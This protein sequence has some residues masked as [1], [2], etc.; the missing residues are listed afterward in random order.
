MK[1]FIKTLLLI[2]L[3]LI[4]FVLIFLLYEINFYNYS[5]FKG[6]FVK[7]MTTEKNDGLFFVYETVRYPSNV[8]IIELENNSNLTLGL[9]NEPWN[10]NFGVMP[11]GILSKRFINLANGKEEIYK[12]EIHVYG[13]ISPM[14]S[15]DKNNFILKKGDEMKVTALL[16]STLSKETGKYIG[17]VD[18]ISKRSK[19][20]FF[21]V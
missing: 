8:E 13:N 5:N 14:V 1:K 3:F 18:I 10:L 16:N 7:N 9:T 21:N 4:L 20:P 17:E 2:P 6:D 11:V 15:F 12:V 19:I